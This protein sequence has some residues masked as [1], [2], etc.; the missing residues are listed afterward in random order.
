[1]SNYVVGW[2]K[3]WRD[4][5]CLRYLEKERG[6]KESKPAYSVKSTVEALVNRILG[7]LFSRWGSSK[8]RITLLM[9][10]YQSAVEQI[11]L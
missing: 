2:D 8:I 9:A 5:L 6:L 3:T 4:I 1:M 11:G 7:S 10:E